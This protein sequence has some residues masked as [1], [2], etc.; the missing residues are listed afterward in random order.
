MPVEQGYGGGTPGGSTGWSAEQRRNAALIVKIGQRMGM[1]RRDILIGLITAAQE[2][3]LKNLKYGD[4]DSQGLFQ[5]R[6]S[7]GWGTVDQVTDPVYATRKF[8]T[9]LQK[10]QG[11]KKMRLTEAAQAVQRSAYPDAYA[12]HV[13]DMRD[14]LRRYAKPGLITPSEA[15]QIPNQGMGGQ[16]ASRETFGSLDLGPDGLGETLEAYGGG[17]GVPA[18]SALGATTDMQTGAP[19]LASP[20]A[21]VPQAPGDLTTLQPFETPEAYKAATGGGR[22]QKGVD[23]TDN[24]IVDFAKQFVGTPY[25]W[26]GTNLQEGVDCSGFLQS[27]FKEFGINLPRVSFQQAAAGDRIGLDKLKPG[28]LVAWD[29]SSRNNGA[30]HIALYIGNG[31]IIEAA[32]PGTNVRIRKLGGDFDKGAWGV[33]LKR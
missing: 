7:Q 6:P 14:M 31:Q 25:V 21:G 10:V 19:G 12:K 5:Q 33:R 13:K 11:R 18:T 24:A 16:P 29:N 30:D 17:P 22:Y 23:N 15:R 8:F 27:V 28:D 3:S 2:S 32:R 9:E 20:L 26:G 4:R 1:S